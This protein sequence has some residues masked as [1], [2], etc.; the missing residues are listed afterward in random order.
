MKE[1]ELI[2]KNIKNK[3]FVPVYFLAGE[4]PFYIDQ[5]L[6]LFENDV[7]SEDE[8]AFN[9]TVVY[10]KDTSYGEILSLARQYPMMGDLQLIIVK[11]AQD[12][13]L[14]EEQCR[15][16]ELY[17]ENP[18]PTTLL[19]FGHKHKKLDKRKKF[20]KILEKQKW[21][22]SSDKI[23]D[24]E[25]QRWIE[26]QAKNL[27]LELS[28]DMAGLLAEHLGTDLSRIYNELEK[29]QMILKPGEKID[30]TFVERH[31]GISK[32]FNVFELQKALGAKDAARAFRIA[33][34]MAQS[35]SFAFPATVAS[36]FRFFTQII[37]FHL[38]RGQSPQTIATEL[39]ISTFHIK[40]YETAARSYPL[41]QATKIISILRESDMK[42]KGLG[43]RKLEDDD[44]LK[45]MV[46]K[47][48]MS[49]SFVMRSK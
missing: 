16:L 22:F 48:L 26:T 18:V 14:N 2:V 20:V 47:I 6:K 49:K 45:E 29:I 7:L 15:A 13:L 39:G 32:E 3:A 11:E 25:V 9:Q 19:V 46:Y 24:W 42:S 23:K 41:K 12:L 28:P 40:E 33:H 21:L 37:L 17:L 1:L 36:V 5:A 4:E 8:K 31:I 30:G 43:S 44:I 35:K 27:K 38:L 10:G 34:F